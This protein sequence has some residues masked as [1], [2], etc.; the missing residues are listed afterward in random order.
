MAATP[1]DP[2][3]GEVAAAARAEW[4]DDELEWTTAAYEQW[5]HRRTLT[6]RAR[7]HLH[8]GDRIAVVLRAGAGPI[9]G[10]VVGVGDDV[11]A[12]GLAGGRVD[13]QL[14]ADRAVAWRVVDRAR[15]GG[16][17]GITVDGFRARLLELEAGG[18]PVDLGTS[19]LDAVARGR[20][21]VGHD[22]VVV[23]DG[24]TV[25]VIGMGAI[26]WVRVTSPE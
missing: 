22:H 4:R 21:T 5:C 20:L 11:L 24:D 2:T 15:S 13:V 3:L 23:D 17:H 19:V 14:R 10:R 18:A 12:L 7:E 26:D 9:V 8:R 6:D 25:T 1:F 16:T